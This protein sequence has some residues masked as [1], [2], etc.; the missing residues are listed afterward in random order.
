MLA[1]LQQE[2]Q[3]KRNSSPDFLERNITSQAAMLRKQYADLL[4]C[5]D[6]RR[7]H[8]LL[9][10]TSHAGDATGSGTTSSGSKGAARPVQ[11]HRLVVAE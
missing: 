2:R 7:L 5:N 10:A 6:A 8:T 4:H 3:Q 9:L 11:V 1:E